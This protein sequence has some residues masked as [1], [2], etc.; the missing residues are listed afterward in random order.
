MAETV[1]VP[2]RK[3][4][5]FTVGGRKYDADRR[6]RIQVENPQHA[7]AIRRA[8]GDSARAVTGFDGAPGRACPGCG[9]HA[10][11]FTVTCPRCGQVLKEG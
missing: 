6:G 11:A 5:G 3:C 10:F 2:D 7:A 8:L 9:F 1:T 4:V